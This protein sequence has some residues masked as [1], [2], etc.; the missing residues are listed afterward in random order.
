MAT[1]S[2]PA[3]RPRVEAF[4]NKE[5]HGGWING[6]EVMGGGNATVTSI[7]PGTG[8]ELARVA[9]LTAEDVAAAVDAAAA[10]FRSNAWSTL[11]INERCAKLHRLAD[12]VEANQSDLAQIESMD[13]GKILSQ[14]EGDVANFVDSIRYY[15]D[16]AQHVQPRT[17]LAVKGHDAWTV[18]HPWGPC[19]FIIPWNFPFLLLGWGLGPALAA[20]NTVVVKPAEDTPL[21]TLY[22]AR[23]AQ[24]AGIPDGVINVVPGRGET[25]GAACRIIPS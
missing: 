21:S 18:R 12:V 8:L 6:R 2:R 17:V 22:V 25:T 24:E 16:L 10:T 23:L 20:G 1:V 5:R 14:A 3:L 19:G 11:P 4:L 15:A 13:A 7:D 9:D